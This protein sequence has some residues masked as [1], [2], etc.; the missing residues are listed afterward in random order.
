M[1]T[2]EV[3][4][5]ASPVTARGY[6]APVAPMYTRMVAVSGDAGA[7]PS[8]RWTV[9]ENR[10]SESTSIG[11]ARQPHCGVDRTAPLTPS[12][13]EPSGPTTFPLITA[14]PNEGLPS[15]GRAQRTGPDTVGW[16]SLKQPATL[17]TT[18][19]A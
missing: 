12:K 14:H 9:T 4:K 6:F 3:S 11:T 15:P 17:M 19:T 13:P 7:G 18:T 2:L 5:Y 10:P 8:L 1:R 16:L